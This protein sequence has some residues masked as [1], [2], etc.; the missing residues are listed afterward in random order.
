MR[1]LWRL[2]TSL[3][4]SLPLRPIARSR[5]GAPEG[6]GSIG[7]ALSLASHRAAA[8]AGPQKIRACIASGN[9]VALQGCDVL[10]FRADRKQNRAAHKSFE[11]C[12]SAT[13][14]SSP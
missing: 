10:G 1:S 8:D 4:S 2:T 13:G 5:H 12:L 14:A 7:T 11:V 9:V 3:A 6:W